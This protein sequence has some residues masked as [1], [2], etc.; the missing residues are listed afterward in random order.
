LS[1]GR[2][3]Q[4]ANYALTQSE[5]NIA[6]GNK[7]PAVYFQD[8]LKQCEG[9]KRKYGGITNPDELKE[10]LWEHCIPEGIFDELSEDYDHFLEER[11]K[12]M[13][14]KIKAYFERL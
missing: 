8:L 14:T 13:A 6:I 10:N 4:I 2:Y 7:A 3:N 9:G 12:R 11:R 5:I 1:R